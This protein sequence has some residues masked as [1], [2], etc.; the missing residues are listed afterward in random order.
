MG[1]KSQL[2]ALLDG[3]EARTRELEI[4]LRGAHARLRR[5]KDVVGLFDVED[6]VLDRAVESEVRGDELFAGAAL[7][8][9][10]RP[11]SSRS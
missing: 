2:M 7:L 1:R 5:G 10:V 11:K 3:A 8:A 4:S 9:R 6:D